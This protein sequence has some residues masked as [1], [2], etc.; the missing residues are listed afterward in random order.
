M[1]V[2]PYKDRSVTPGQRVR[3]VRSAK[4]FWTVKGAGS[5]GLVLGH[6]DSISLENCEITAR[7]IVGKYQ[8]YG[9]FGCDKLVSFKRGRPKLAATGEEV[10]DAQ[11][12]DCDA[13]GRVW[14]RNV[15]TF[16]QIRPA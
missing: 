7:G 11:Y 1:Y 8:P 3:V 15:G 13:E 5:R 14:A 9:T 4:G 6:A 10:G 12:V 2:T 16:W